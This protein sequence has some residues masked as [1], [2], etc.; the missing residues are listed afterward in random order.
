MHKVEHV[1]RRIEAGR[2]AG[3]HDVAGSGYIIAEHFTRI[4]ADKN[5]ACA[6]HFLG[7]APR[8]SPPTGTGVPA[9]TGWQA[10][11]LHP[12]LLVNTAPLRCASD[13]WITLTR[14]RLSAALNFC[15]H[16][17]DQALRGGQQDGGCQHIVF[18]L[19]Q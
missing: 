19:G 12:G 17:L 7:T 11:A 10:R 16:G 6:G 14:L 13:S 18:G 8:G 15:L 3:G 2:T 4:L 1:Q 5:T 9:H